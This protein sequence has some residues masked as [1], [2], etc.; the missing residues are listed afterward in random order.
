MP[1]LLENKKAY[2]DYEILEKYEAGLELRGYEVKSLKLKRGNIQGARA[3]IRGGEAYIVGMDIPPY[4][5]KNTPKDYEPQRTR[6][7]LLHKKEISRMAGKAEERGLTIVPT[8][9]YT[10][11]GRIKVEIAVVRAKKKYDKRERIKEREENRTIERT[12]KRG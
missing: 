5:P 8:K 1:G 6:K 3:I 9:V 11:G 10:S 12:L 7:L 2:F 4:Q